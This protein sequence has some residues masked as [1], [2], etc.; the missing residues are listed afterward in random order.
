MSTRCLLIDPHEPLFGLEIAS[1]AKARDIPIIFDVEHHTPGLYEMIGVSDYVIGAEEAIRTLGVNTPE[2]ALK[3]AVSFGPRAA[4]ITPGA[5]GSI[6]MADK[7]IIRHSAF[8]V[9][10][11]GT[12][13]AGDA[14]HAGFAYG[15]LQ[16]WDL[17]DILNFSNAM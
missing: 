6:A 1:E 15:L 10:V 13:A 16:N 8:Q 11:I 4:V 17:M 2:E 5:K 14:F 12:T 9:E 7:K 3:K